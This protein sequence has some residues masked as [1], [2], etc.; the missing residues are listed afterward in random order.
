MAGNKKRAREVHDEDAADPG[1]EKMDQDES[2]D[3]DDD[4]S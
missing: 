4:V 3:D 2:S 1:M